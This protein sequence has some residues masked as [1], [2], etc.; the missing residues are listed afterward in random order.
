MVVFMSYTLIVIGM[1]DSGTTKLRNVTQINT[2]L[3]YYNIFG[4]IC[5]ANL[6][7][8]CLIVPIT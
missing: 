2:S 6:S 1:F 8:P 7:G 3:H 5:V 4:N